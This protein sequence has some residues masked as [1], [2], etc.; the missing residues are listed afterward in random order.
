MS[1]TSKLRTAIGV[2]FILTI[3][4]AISVA[5]QTP[6]VADTSSTS[7]AT[8]AATTS[9]PKKAEGTKPSTAS[10]ET[11]VPDKSAEASRK[12]NNS[13]TSER[14]PADPPVIP[15]PAA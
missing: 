11:A 2:V 13:S 10:T 4:G 5:A 15:T 7:A 12:A 6:T 3:A 9:E 14:V 8:N 1:L